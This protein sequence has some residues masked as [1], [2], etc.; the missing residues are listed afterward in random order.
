MAALL[1][2]ISKNGRVL[3]V[4]AAPAEARAVESGFR[5]ASI[6]ARADAAWGWPLRP[7]A[8]G[9]DLVETGVGKVNAGAA[10]AIRGPDFGVVVNLGVC[11]SL[12]ID[13][14]PRIGEAVLASVSVYADEGVQTEAGWQTL[15]GMGFALGP[16]AGVGIA[17]DE[18]LR[19]AL[20]PLAARIA[21]VATVSTCSGTD[22][23]ARAVALRTGAAAEA[24]EGAAIGH[25]L[26]RVSPQT[27]FAEL[28]TVSNTT[29]DR[30]LQ[31]W[32][33]R[34]ALARLT[35]IAAAI[36]GSRT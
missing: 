26:A 24:M 25:V 27:R 14:A 3:L 21:P 17:C 1:R 8:E 34:G 10:A 9:I 22:A 4:V 15:P 7:L 29:G 33:L 16:F 32:D 31:R 18:V 28:R 11:G 19:G 13:N 35:D 20:A 30:A 23:L 6:E 12:P 2:E 5:V 36:A